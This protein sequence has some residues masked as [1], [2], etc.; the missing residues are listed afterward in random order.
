[1][2][3]VVHGCDIKPSRCNICCEENRAW[4]HFEP[5]IHY[6]ADVTEGVNHT[7][8]PVEIVESLPLL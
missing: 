4:G 7:D 3:N 5:I 2:N 1:M 8:L 6:I